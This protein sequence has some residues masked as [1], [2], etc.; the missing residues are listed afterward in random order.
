MLYE[1]KFN[2]DNMIFSIIVLNII[3]LS[4]MTLSIRALIIMTLRIKGLF[5]TFSIMTLS[6][7]TASIIVSYGSEA[8]HFIYIFL[9][10]TMLSRYLEF[11][12]AEN[13]HA[14]W[15]FAE[16]CGSCIDLS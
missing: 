10:C 12:Y 8:C 1:K 15:R 6:I 16:C 4:I 5:V 3:A 13:Q 2:N 11:H 14:Y 7:M 9:A